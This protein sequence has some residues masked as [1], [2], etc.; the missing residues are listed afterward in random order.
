M[1]EFRNTKEEQIAEIP[2]TFGNYNLQLEEIE[3]VRDPDQDNGK[4]SERQKK[5]QK[6]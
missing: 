2:I 1:E 5:S 4:A 6:A 3:E